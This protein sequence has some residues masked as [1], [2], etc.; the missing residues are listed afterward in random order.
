M[1]LHP[2]GD[3]EYLLRMRGTISSAGS[4]SGTGVQSSYVLVVYSI[5]G[6][7]DKAV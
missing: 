5:G 4:I 2:L 1:T 3:S 6:T 7:S